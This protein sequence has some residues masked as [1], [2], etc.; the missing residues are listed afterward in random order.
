[1]YMKINHGPTLRSHKDCLGMKTNH[2]QPWLTMVQCCIVTR[3]FSIWKSNMV[4]HVYFNF[5]NI[6]V[7]VYILWVYILWVYNFYTFGL[8]L[9]W[10]YNINPLVLLM[11][12][13]IF[14]GFNIIQQWS[15]MVQCRIVTRIV[16]I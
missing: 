4:N 6:H 11:K 9:P 15:T 5:Y 8:L 3:T 14:L 2:G 13:L 7:R 1:M 10:V 12:V 16:S